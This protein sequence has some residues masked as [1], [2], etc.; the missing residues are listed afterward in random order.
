MSR[1]VPLSLLLVLATSLASPAAVAA[2]PPESPDR[3]IAA[4][5]QDWLEWLWEPVARL[6]GASEGGPT[7][8]PNGAT[9]GSGADDPAQSS[10]SEGSETDGGP[11]MD[12]DG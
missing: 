11:T 6:L 5:A 8:D 2:A 12:P 3:G 4:A 10:P 7:M 1:L 9:V